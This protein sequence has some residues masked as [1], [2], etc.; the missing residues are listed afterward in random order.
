ML[1]LRAAALALLLGVAGG[2][3]AGDD[4]AGVLSTQIGVAPAQVVVKRVSGTSRAPGDE[5]VPGENEP[6]GGFTVDVDV[7]AP[8][9]RRVAYAV[10]SDFSHMAAF[11]P[12]VERSEVL[13]REGSRLRVLQRGRMRYGL[14]SVGF[15][16]IRDVELQPDRILARSISGTARHMESELRFEAERSERGDR[17]DG[18]PPETRFHYHAWIVPEMGLPPLIGPA[19]VR[20]EVAEQFTAMVREMVRRHTAAR[21]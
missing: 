1:G 13:A 16:S 14:F 15:E 5:A 21:P 8:V 17:P 11:V 20:H 7:R 10:L 2:A 9:P 18:D 3:Q 19:A 4:S 12:N 6:G